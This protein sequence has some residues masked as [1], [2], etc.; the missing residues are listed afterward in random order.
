MNN[1]FISDEQLYEIIKEKTNNALTDAEMKVVFK[2][3]KD[4][5]NETD[6]KSDEN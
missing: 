3:M 4:L 1:S 6:E 2:I 5:I